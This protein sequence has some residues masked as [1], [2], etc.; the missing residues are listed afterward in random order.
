MSNNQLS[1]PIS[2]AQFMQQRQAEDAYQDQRYFNRK[3]AEAQIQA[4]KEIA[5]CAAKQQILTQAATD[6]NL[7]K[8]IQREE[9]EEIR[10]GSFQE[11]SIADNG[12][13][14]AT[15]KNLFKNAQPRSIVNIS[16]PELE[17]Y[18]RLANRTDTA[19][20]LVGYVGG[21]EK[22]IFLD[23]EKIGT[24]S[25]LVRKFAAHGIIFHAD[26]LSQ[27]KMYAQQ[28]VSLLLTY[29]IEDFYIA[30]NPGWLNQPDGSYVFYKEENILWKT[31]AKRIR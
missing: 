22:Q 21:C 29:E 7:K 8:M 23:A 19:Y 4:E 20:R 2:A 31:I 1:N 11:I 9:I 27:Q 18:I 17:R 13:I 15:T 5:V 28:F 26:K 30:D 6:R 10:R 25:Y 16:S 14:I 12:E 3:N 24:G